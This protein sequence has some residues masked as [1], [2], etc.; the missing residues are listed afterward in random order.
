VTDDAS[1]PQKRFIEQALPILESDER[2]EAVLVAGSSI[3]GTTDA[4][5]D[6]DLVIVCR[7]G[8]HAATL[9][10]CRTIAKSLGRLLAAFTGEHVGE[11]RVLICLYA[12]PLLHVDLKFVRRDDLAHRVETPL[13]AFDRHGTTEAA[14]R[15]GSASW[16]ARES[17]WFEER[18]WI[19]VHYGATKIA[20]G[21]L[22]EA[23]DM[24]AFLRAQVL[25]P[26]LA[27]NGG[28]RQR[29]VRQIEF[30][31]PAHVPELAR[32]VARYDREDCW[33]ALEAA[34]DIYLS[35]RRGR[36]P[37]NAAPEIERAVLSYI[38]AH[39]SAR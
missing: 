28:R 17:E 14:L 13:L 11:P 1:S 33:R 25:G 3:S 34:A 35:Y 24:L 23:H 36:L 10:E 22:F 8:D 6:V 5:S 18:F 9:A 30:E 32:T 15:T 2:I 21:E 7:D 4:F 19:W 20:R 27:R 38:A 31:A 26:M 12:D 39:R 37:G 16:P 29:G